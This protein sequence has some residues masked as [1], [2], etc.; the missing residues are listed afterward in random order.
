MIYTCHYCKRT[1]GFGVVFWDI[2]CC[3]D[4]HKAKFDQQPKEQKQPHYSGK[5]EFWDEHKGYAEV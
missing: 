5:S 1:V 4:C 2:S 3:M